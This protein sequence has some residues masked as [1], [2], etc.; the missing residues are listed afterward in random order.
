VWTA[1]N[2]PDLYIAVRALGGE[3]K[4]TVHAPHPPHTEWERHFGFD[5]HAAS[6][7]SQE[8]KKD[9]GP[10]KV[11]W[12]G[13]NIAADTTVEYRVNI[14]GTSLEDVGQP[15]TNDVVLLPVPSRDEYVEVVVIL[16]PVGSTS[17]YPR[18]RDGTTHLIGEGLLSDGRCVWVVYVVRPMKK[19]GENV[20]VVEPSPIVPEKSFIDPDADL[21]SASLRVMA[22]GAQADGTL[23]F[24]DLKA[25]LAPV[26]AERNGDDGDRKK[27]NHDPRTEG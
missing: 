17:D 21:N 15:V 22:F 6:S 25:T 12:T 9:G 3:L 24:L 7:V 2:K 13:C 4:A 27:Q 16:G 11:R 23:A 8:A 19:E 14:R 10:H 18:D 20:A 5:K 26:T 1:K